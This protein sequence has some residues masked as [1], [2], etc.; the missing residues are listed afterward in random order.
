MNI[1]PK[2]NIISSSHRISTWTSI[3]CQKRSLLFSVIHLGPC[4]VVQRDVSSQ[5][6]LGV[7]SNLVRPSK[8]SRSQS[9]LS[10]ALIDFKR[11]LQPDI[12]QNT[13]SCVIWFEEKQNHILLIGTAF[14]A[15]FGT[16]IIIEILCI[17][18]SLCKMLSTAFRT[19]CS[20]EGNRMWT[21]QIRM[22]YS[23]HP[24]PLVLCGGRHQLL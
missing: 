15:G 11:W 13:R 16:S 17:S 9:C 20:A 5:A 1:I 24:Y 4:N 22:V 19:D 14:C 10:W 7:L 6:F 21:H 18:I 3:L 23:E 8:Y 2:T 12:V